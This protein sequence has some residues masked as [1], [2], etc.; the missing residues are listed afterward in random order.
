MTTFTRPPFEDDPIFNTKTWAHLLSPSV[1]RCR[2]GKRYPG[3][4]KCTCEA[5]FKG[6]APGGGKIWGSWTGPCPIH[7]KE[8]L[9]EL[10]A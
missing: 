5:E 10:E 6:Y 1:F 9:K 4:R 3:P 2:I 7:D 8:K